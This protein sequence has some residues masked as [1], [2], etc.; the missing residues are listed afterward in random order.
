MTVRI[1]AHETVHSDNLE[2]REY[3]I[4]FKISSRTSRLQ[5]R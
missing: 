5:I 1:M 4:A 2:T 3:D